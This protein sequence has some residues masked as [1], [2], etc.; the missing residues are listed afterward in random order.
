MERKRTGRRVVWIV[1]AG[2]M[3]VGLVWPVAAEEPVLARLSFWVPLER[4]DQFEAAYEE[5]LLPIL[6]KH[7]LVESSQRGRATVDSVFNRLFVVQAL[8]E[9]GGRSFGV[10]HLHIPS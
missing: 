8:I 10:E 4:M 2:L 3:L 1:A 9:S 6:K 7:G 5:Q